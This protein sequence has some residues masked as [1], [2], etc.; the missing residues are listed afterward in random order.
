MLQTF[1]KLL[2]PA[3]TFFLGGKVTNP[4]SALRNLDVPVA[5][6]WATHATLFPVL[7]FIISLPVEK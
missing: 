1:A 2:L 6:F 4:P 5:P 7:V 3:L